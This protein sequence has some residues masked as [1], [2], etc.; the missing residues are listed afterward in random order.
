MIRKTLSGV[1]AAAA[2]VLIPTA[3]LAYVGDDDVTASTTTPGVGEAFEVYVDGDDDVTEITLT[4]ES[5]DASVPDSD[6]EI[7]GVAALTKAADADGDATFYVTLYSEGAYT[8]VATDQDGETIGTLAVNVGETA[9]PTPTTTATP[10]P[11]SSPLPDTGA[12]GATPLALA[13][14]VV[15]IAGGGA[16]AFAR[17]RQSQIG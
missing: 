7:A 11:T 10:S 4:V 13:A 6:I 5:A 1:A 17:R 14:S 8:L 12:S 9:S 3:A 2:L 16:L 15:L